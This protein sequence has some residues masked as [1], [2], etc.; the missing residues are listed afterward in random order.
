[1][2][3]DQMKEELQWDEK[4]SSSALSMGEIGKVKLE[5]N[6]EDE[7]GTAQT[8][9]AEIDEELAI[10]D[11]RFSADESPSPSKN[12]IVLRPNRNGKP[13][14]VRWERQKWLQNRVPYTYTELIAMAINSQSDQRATLAE[15]YEYLRVH[16][17]CFR[18]SYTGWKNCIR[19]TLT[20]A[21]SFQK[22]PRAERAGRVG[23]GNYWALSEYFHRRN[24]AGEIGRR[25]RKA[26]DREVTN[27]D[28]TQQ[29]L[30]T[31]EAAKQSEKSVVGQNK[32]PNRWEQQQS[33]DVE[34]LLRS[35]GI[36]SRATSGKEQQKDGSREEAAGKADNRLGKGQTTALS[37][38]GDAVAATEG[39]SKA[40]QSG[41]GNKLDLFL[42][43][44]G[45]LRSTEC[46]PAS[47]PSSLHSSAMPSSSS[48]AVPHLHDCAIPT[49]YQLLSPRHFPKASPPTD[50]L[51][52]T[53]PFASSFPSLAS[54]LFKSDS[55]PP[56]GI[57]Q[58]QIQRHQQKSDE[59]NEEVI[60]VDEED[61]VDAEEQQQQVPPFRHNSAAHSA[62]GP[63]V[64]S[65]AQVSAWLGLVAG[66]MRLR[67]QCDG[68]NGSMVLS[69]NFSGRAVHRLQFVPGN[70]RE[71]TIR[72]FAGDQLY[73]EKR[74]T[75]HDHQEEQTLHAIRGICFH[76]FFCR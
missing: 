48:S 34:D 68:K 3:T 6:G 63:S 1:M 21:K 32:V 39:Q 54:S 62:A 43:K 60:T 20:L 29:N 15:I 33:N 58:Q 42:S 17:D 46:P 70:D 14:G 65:V 69:P 38:E 2:N 40:K 23:L 52:M 7:E 16:F 74:W 19:H 35:I 31:K 71:L 64:A 10:G 24:L 12:G 37:T 47:A 9:T 18:G 55:S 76:F 11:H 13:K 51:R 28:E 50:H 27:A 73:Q 75:W 56:F 4:A 72:Q 66:E 41:T 57:R 25:A 61:T 8:L 59:V 49:A 67:L 26:V 5:E 36:P 30:H 44:M 53:H 45:R 22:V